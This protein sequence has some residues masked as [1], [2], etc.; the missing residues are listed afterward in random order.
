M[1]TSDSRKDAARFSGGAFETVLPGEKLNV[2]AGVPDPGVLA[3]MANEF[4]TALPE[5]SQ[6]EKSAAAFPQASAAV[7]SASEA[8]NALGNTATLTSP[9]A[10][11][12]PSEAELRALPASLA[13]GPATPPLVAGLSPAALP[14]IPGGAGATNFSAL[15]SFSFLDEIRPLFS[16]PL[17]SPLAAVPAM[18]AVKIPGETELRALANHFSSTATPQILDA[19][20]HLGAPQVSGAAPQVGALDELVSFAFLDEIRQLAP[21][22]TLPAAAEPLRVI[23]CVAG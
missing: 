21:A 10:T 2:P 17:A 14:G 8:L 1:S 20:A 9:L 6:A 15:P 11:G 22:G 16:Y 4:F 23:C 18:P 12:F 19:G 3:R 7:P 5:L 13:S